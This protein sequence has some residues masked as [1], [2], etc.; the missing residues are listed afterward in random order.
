MLIYINLKIMKLMKYLRLASLLVIIAFVSSKGRA[1]GGYYYY[2]ADYL[3]YTLPEDIATV[4]DDTRNCL[5]WQE[6]TGENVPLDDIREVVYKYSIDRVKGIIGGESLSDNKFEQWIK[7]HAD[8]EVV[9]YLVLAKECEKTRDTMISP[10]YYPTKN[11]ACVALLSGIKEKS[12]C[13][14]G[15]RLKSRYILQCVRAMFALMDYNGCISL[16]NNVCVAMPDDVIKDMAAH[17]I[18]GAYENLGRTDEAMKMYIVLGDYI[19]ASRCM[20][21]DYKKMSAIDR[22]DYAVG[23]NP[24]SDRIIGALKRFISNG[25]VVLYEDYYSEEE[26]NNVRKDF[27][28]LYDI[29]LKASEKSKEM[30]AVWLYTAGFLS[31]CRHEYNLAA[32]HIAAAERANDVSSLSS[33]INVLKIYIDAETSEFNA[34]YEKRLEKQ[35]LWFE[36]MIRTNLTP[37]IKEETATLWYLKG[38]FSYYYWNDMFRKIML[39]TVCRRMA[40]EKMEVRALQIANVADNMLINMVGN[41]KL[42]DYWDED[43]D[44]GGK[45]MQLEDY[46]KKSEYNAI[47]FSNYFFRLADT[48]NL[49]CLKSY[50]IRMKHPEN[51]FDKFLAAYSYFD[52]DYLN[53]IIGT[54]CLRARKY[55][56]A[57][58]YLGKVPESYEHRLNTRKYLTID[59]FEVER[60]YCEDI[61]DAKMRFAEEMM[62]LEFIMKNVSEPNRKALAQLKYALGLKSSFGHS[63]A[64]THYQLSVYDDWSESKETKLVLADAERLKKEALEMFTDDEIA[65]EAHAI[66]DSYIAIANRYRHTAFSKILMGRCD[67]Y[68]DYLRKM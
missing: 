28:R 47:D 64:Y 3:M 48:V 57:V 46:R 44:N 61:I 6:L 30:K 21:D 4:G 8:T 1:C 15:R 26:K 20:G 12:M 25:E 58:I 52:E 31:V 51:H 5:L 50:V 42:D 13:Y 43:T 7:R 67:S 34:A 56:D 66:Y 59:P 29:S 41:I 37:E 14:D 63:W 27:D 35:I 39:G 17:Y 2:P 40:N 68:R 16:W 36:S 45:Y 23:I 55:E 10:W 18:A 53:D 11:D 22:I 54:R 33:V 65:A 32:K 19:S 60:E 49:E 62:R 9:D 24:D 38:N